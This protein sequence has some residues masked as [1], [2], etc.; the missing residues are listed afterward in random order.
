MDVERTG[1]AEGRFAVIWVRL[2][3][4]NLTDPTIAYQAPLAVTDSE[5]IFDPAALSPAPDVVRF[6]TRD[7][8]VPADCPCTGDFQAAVAYL[9]V[10]GDENMD[11]SVDASEVKQG[12]L[13]GIANTAM[14]QSPQ[15]FPI[16]PA[17][18]SSRFP[19]GVEE[20]TFAYRIT[21]SGAFEPTDATRFKLRAGAPL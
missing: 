2:D 6:C 20:G 1:D 4:A 18:F 17:E 13:F 19:Q 3:G 12:N 8:E 15:S 11:G 7:C 5:V 21:E 14:V 16:V 10:V 9:M